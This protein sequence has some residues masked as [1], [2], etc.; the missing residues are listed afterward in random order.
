MKYHWVILFIFIYPTTLLFSQVDSIKFTHDFHF[1]EGIYVTKQDL[2][3]N[4]PNLT[5]ENFAKYNH[6]LKYLDNNFFESSDYQ[7]YVKRH[8]C[9]LDKEGIIQ[10]ISIDSIFGFVISGYPF[11]YYTR[12]NKD[13]FKVL[14]MFRLGTITYCFET[15]ASSSQELIPS[16]IDQKDNNPLLN[17][18]ITP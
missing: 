9:Y 4:S 11:T 12:P 1:R 3:N 10:R 17:N 13:G 6:K 18:L 2:I 15:Q 7:P 5:S 8:I 14:R 16:G